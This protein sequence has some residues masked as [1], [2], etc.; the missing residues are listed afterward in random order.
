MSMTNIM[1]NNMVGTVLIFGG[2]IFWGAYIRGGG[3]YITQWNEVS[4]SSVHVVG[5]YTG[6]YIQRFTVNS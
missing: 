2:L 3:A 1:L 6:G 5:L 4:V